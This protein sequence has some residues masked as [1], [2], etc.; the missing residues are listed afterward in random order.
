MKTVIFILLILSLYFGICLFIGVKC[1]LIAV[2]ILLIVLATVFIINKNFFEK[3]IKFVNPKYAILYN[4]K[5]DKFR[6]RLKITDIVIFYLLSTFM[7]FM[8]L[9]IP[10]I[11]LPLN[12]RNMIALIIGAAFFSI[13]IWYLG[14]FI[15]KKSK[16]NSS[17]WFYFTAL[18]LFVVLILAF[19]I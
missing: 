18:I 8:A 5:D 12:Q 6:K 16:T 17:F 9:N 3:Y 7:L 4:E 19:I 1:A 11:T 14:L 13:L 10:N 2:A 15:L